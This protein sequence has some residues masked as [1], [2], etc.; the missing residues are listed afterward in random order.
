MAMNLP[1]NKCALQ[2]A[3]QCPPASG[4]PYK[5][6]LRMQTGLRNALNDSGHRSLGS[7]TQVV[8]PP[9]LD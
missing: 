6:N 3:S 1:A 8:V 7:D 5:E 2:C 9:I 4:W